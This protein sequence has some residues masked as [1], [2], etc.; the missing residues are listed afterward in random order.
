MVAGWVGQRPGL[1]RTMASV[2][3]AASGALLWGLLAMQQAGVAAFYLPGV[4][5]KSYKMRENVS[6]RLR[7]LDGFGDVRNGLAGTSLARTDE[8]VW[9]FGAR[10]R[11]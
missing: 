10:P 8:S 4:A 11:G 2:R 3:Q 1:S 9:G 7:P 6:A 5:P